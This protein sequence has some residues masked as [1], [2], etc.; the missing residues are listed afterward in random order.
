M[1]N[2]IGCGPLYIF[3]NYYCQKDNINNLQ[4]RLCKIFEKWRVIL[5]VISIF[6]IKDMLCSL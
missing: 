3:I 5:S 4:G 1:L 6:F 2:H